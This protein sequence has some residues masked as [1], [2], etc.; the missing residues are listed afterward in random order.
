MPRQLHCRP[1]VFDCVKLRLVSRLWR[2]LLVS[3]YGYYTKLLL[4]QS[5]QFTWLCTSDIQALAP[6]MLATRS[7]NMP[8]GTQAANHRFEVQLVRLTIAAHAQADAGIAAQVKIS[9][10]GALTTKAAAL[11]QNRS[12]SRTYCTVSLSGIL[13]AELVTHCNPTA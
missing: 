9:A 13:T 2:A 1:L 4:S 12:C 6:E 5:M 11:L 3:L 7:R 8:T 10:L